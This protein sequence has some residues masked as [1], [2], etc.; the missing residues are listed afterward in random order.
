[1]DVNK[2]KC[3]SNWQPQLFKN[4]APTGTPVKAAL[5]VARRIQSVNP[6]LFPVFS[7]GHLAH[8]ADVPYKFLRS[9]VERNRNV[10]PYKV[11][12][13]EKQGAAN[14]GQIRWISAPHPLLLQVQRW[15]NSN[16]L[17][18]L[19]VHDC[20]YAYVKNRSV[21]DAAA[22]HKGSKWI[23]KVDVENFFESILETK[24]YQVFRRAGY[25]PLLCFELSR[26]CTRI[27][28]PDRDAKGPDGKPRVR[29]KGR[30]YVINSYASHS[31]GHL[32]QGAATS[33]ALANIVA[34]QL[35][36]KIL[37]LA[38]TYDLRYSRYSD[39]IILSTRSA[40]FRKS[41]AYE[42]VGELY[43]ILRKSGFEPN[44]K[45][46]KVNGP[47]SK[48]LVLGFLVDSDAPRLTREF[49]DKLRMHLYF[50]S[51]NGPTAHAV[52]RK[53][54]SVIGLK[55]HL[56]GLIS[57]AR[58]ADIAFAEECMDK[59]NRCNW[60][61]FTSANTTYLEYLENI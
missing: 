42:V 4:D 56:I 7:L 3:M 41:V 18:H 24:V 36:D 61:I 34:Y 43:R 51:K 47:G 59:L 55:N 6:N 53:F 49:K 9:I 13:I 26:L 27:M 50:C 12:F 57:Y 11:F 21:F 39:D 8:C 30:H 54:D 31:L 20:A 32:P 16:I 40:N 23:I 14:I 19:A 37:E 35:D 17:A 10:E 45:K 48:R 46:T 52:E 25:Q 29:T 60:P 38:E 2:C 22:I 28:N 33:P 44:V 5:E 1:M 58:T 15:I